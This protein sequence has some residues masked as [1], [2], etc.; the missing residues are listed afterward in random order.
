MQRGCG[1]LATPKVVGEL[2]HEKVR[3]GQLKA[4]YDDRDKC[5]HV[6][7]YSCLLGNRDDHNDLI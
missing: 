4:F 5:L 7:I 3:E 1:K 6:E 2:G